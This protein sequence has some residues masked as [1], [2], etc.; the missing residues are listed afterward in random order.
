MKINRSLRIYNKCDQNM[1][2]LP[3]EVTFIA[4]S[5]DYEWLYD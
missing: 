4:I 3:T 1:N 5:Y 2:L